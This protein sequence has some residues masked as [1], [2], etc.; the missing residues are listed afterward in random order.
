[1]HKRLAAIQFHPDHLE[2]EFME[3][4][5]IV[6]V[7]FSAAQRRNRDVV[8]GVA[9]AKQLVVAARFSGVWH[10]GQDIENIQAKWADFAFRYQRLLPR[11]QPIGRHNLFT[12]HVPSSQRLEPLLNSEFRL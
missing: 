8:S 11:C 9:Q 10:V 12:A 4:V 3:P 5:D 7:G 2:S 6:L 1:L